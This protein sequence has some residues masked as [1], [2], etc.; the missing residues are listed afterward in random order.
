M[1]VFNAGVGDDTIIINVSNIT[2]LEQTG[3]GN[4]ARVDGGGGIDV[5]QLEGADLTLDLTKISDRRIQDIEVIDIT[6]S[7]DNTLR[8]NLDDLLDASTSTNILKVL[9]NSQKYLDECL[10]LNC[11]L[12]LIVG[13]TGVSHFYHFD[14]G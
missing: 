11:P 5:L 10:Y 14:F 6:G 2:A 7:G 8:L 12:E 13:V 1:D 4:R 9:G 3:V